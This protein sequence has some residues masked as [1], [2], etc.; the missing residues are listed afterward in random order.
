VGVTALVVVFVDALGSGGVDESVVVGK[1]L[2]FGY[3]S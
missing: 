1:K 3:L 2:C